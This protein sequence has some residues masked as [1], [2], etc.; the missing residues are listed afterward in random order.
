MQHNGPFILS[1]ITDPFLQ[2][3]SPHSSTA[4]ETNFHPF[5]FF[6]TDKDKQKALTTG[7]LSE[8]DGAVQAAAQ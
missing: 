4:E 3:A 5:R 7:M 1:D 6:P 8:H 2:V